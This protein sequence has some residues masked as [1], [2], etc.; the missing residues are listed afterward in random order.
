V[1]EGAVAVIG[2][3]IQ[4]QREHSGQNEYM[5]NLVLKGEGGVDGM[6]ISNFVQVFEEPTA[7]YTFLIR[8]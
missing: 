7:M 3:Y 1:D 4:Y 8:N 2:A 5:L 6:V